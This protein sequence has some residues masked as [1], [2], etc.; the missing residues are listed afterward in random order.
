MNTPSVYLKPLSGINLI[1]A[2]TNGT[3]WVLDSNRT[4]TWAVSD[5]GPYQWQNLASNQANFANAYASFSAFINV[6]FTYVGYYSKPNSA[7]ANLVISVDGSNT[8][9]NNSNAW[10]EGFFPNNVLVQQMLPT[11]V[12]GYYPNAPGDIWINLNS[13]L[14]HQP[15]YAVGTI[16]F[17]AFIHEIGH[18]LG[19]KHPHD[20]GGTGHP[21][22]A[23]VGASLLDV[24]WFTIMS[25]NDSYPLSAIQWHPATP[26]IGDVIALQSI[27]GPNLSV[28]T[29]NDTYSIGNNN[30]FQTIFDP[31]GTNT[32]DLRQSHHS[33]NLNLAVSAPNAI[34]PFQIGLATPNDENLSVPSSLYWLYGN[35]QVVHC[36][37]QNDYIT[38]SPI[39][40]TVFLGAGADTIVGNSGLNKVIDSG[41]RSQYTIV[42]IG[43]SYFLNDNTGTHGT[44]TLTN[45]QRFQ[46]SDI[47]IAF[48][49]NG[50]AGTAAKILGAV[51]GAASVQ[52]KEYVGIGL[53]YLDNG[54][55]Y[56]NLMQLALNA[57]GAT[58]NTA[59]VNLLFS[60][61]FGTV[62]TSSQAA[63]F[64]A[65]LDSGAYSAGTFGV[66][67][68][69]YNANN[70]N[71]IDLVGLQQTG[72]QYV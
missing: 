72:I 48:D 41:I 53:S 21:I 3:Y 44:D 47:S 55:S 4:L 70:T 11:S 61:L 13:E 36:S 30:M 22:F 59:V 58:T 1:D 6:N 10:A 46:F 28:H 23:N 42:K 63:P 39:G 60:N 27:Y 5:F 37:N 2:L 68:A 18:T 54:M 57:A 15:S 67:A 32:L 14:N 51:F 8:F 65:M 34:H 43:S 71:H 35:F 19:L 26:M 29:G 12:V 49:I 52:N 56:A 66:V 17:T 64:V 31:L 20:D 50:N 25:Y 69:D 24:D 45:I 7:P 16:G 33:W 62:P 40:E 9:F 38:C